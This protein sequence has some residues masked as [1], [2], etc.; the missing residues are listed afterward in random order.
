MAYFI[1]AQSLKMFAGNP[2]N[3]MDKADPTAAGLLQNVQQIVTQNPTYLRALTDDALATV[4]GPQ[5]GQLAQQLGQ[6][7][8]DPR[9]SE[10]LTKYLQNLK[11]IGVTQP[12]NQQIGRMGVNPQANNIQTQMQIKQPLTPPQMINAQG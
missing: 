2:P 8:P 12:E 7:N 6:R 1:G 9:F 4:A 5:A 11:F 10:L 3:F